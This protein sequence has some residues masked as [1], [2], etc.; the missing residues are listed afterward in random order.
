MAG[1]TFTQAEIDAFR[2]SM[3][4]NPGVLEMRIGDRQYK[5]DTMQAMEDRLAYMTRHLDTGANAT[6]TRYGATS[7]GA[8]SPGG[9]TDDTR[10]WWQR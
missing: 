2:A 8:S 1:I 4:Q 9:W 6:K 3:L 5:F 7:K 10:W